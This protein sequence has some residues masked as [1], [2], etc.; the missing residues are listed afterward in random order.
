V[1]RDRTNAE[2]TA[3]E[4]RSFL[5]ERLPRYMVPAV[6]RRFD[7]FPLTPNG[8]IDRNALQ[9]LYCLGDGESP[10]AAG[11][12]SFLE[13]TL[14]KLFQDILE[15]RDFGVHDSFFD[16]GG[17]SLSVMGLVSGVADLTGH[18][19]SIGDLFSAPTV[20]ELGR[21]LTADVTQNDKTTQS[22]VQI[23]PRGEEAP[24]FMVHGLSG[25]VFGYLSLAAALAPDRPAFGVQAINACLESVEEM[26]TQ[27]AAQIRQAWPQGPYHLIGFS[28]GAWFAYAIGAE[29]LRQDAALGMVCMLDPEPVARPHIQLRLL[30]LI[31]RTRKV[32]LA[33]DF[34]AVLRVAQRAAVRL[35]QLLRPTSGSSSPVEPYMPHILRFR[36]RQAALHVDAI[37]THTTITHK[38]RFI[39]FYAQRGVTEH[40]LF[41]DHLDFIREDRS[42]ELAEI[43]RTILRRVENNS[44]N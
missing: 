32:V 42:P 4:F 1:D 19:I 13:A 22:I 29:L 17:D 33:G 27:Y 8:K 21:L 5:S 16:L 39:R 28:A 2:P 24:V 34:R 3:D 26:A 43:L 23:Q 20:A 44:R 15:R 38:S 18:E 14:L 36:P 12:C 25:D 10:S 31:K 37:A 6:F 9:T 7:A 35:Q 30:F 11:P 41:T 40:A